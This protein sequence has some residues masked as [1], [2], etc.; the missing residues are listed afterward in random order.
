[1][2]VIFWGIFR[3]ETFLYM[4]KPL[5]PAMSG[6]SKPNVA[7]IGAGPGGLASALLLAKSGVDVTVFERSS[8][9]GGRNKVFERDG[10]KFDLGPTFFHY[11]EVIEDIFKAIGMDAHEELRLHRLEMNYRLIFGQGGQLDCTSDLD[12][13]TER[14]RGLSGDSNANAFRRYVDD[15]RL[16]LA[17]S[18]ACLQEPWY[19]PT[20]LLSKRAMRVAG[21]LRPQRSVAGDLMKLF[22]DDRLMLAMSFQTKY[23]GM[24]P[25]NCPSLFTMLAFLEYEYGIFHP[26]GGLGSVSERMASIAKDLGV[27]FKMNEAVESVIM[28]GK[29][30]KGVR[31]ANGE[32]MADK[33]VMNADF[34]NGMTQLFPDKVRKK[35]SNKKIDKKKYSCSTFMLYL[36]IDKT[37]EELPHHQIYASS[38]YEKNLEDIEKNHK[39]T[40]DDP[41][42]YVQNAC[43]VDPSLAPEGCS[44]VYA[45]VPVSHIHEN[46]DWDKEKDAYRDRIIEQIETKLGFEGLRDHIVTEMVITPEDW[47]DHCYRGAVFNLAHGLDQMLWRRPK[48]QFD[49]INNLY[50][51]GGGTHPGS[52][53]PV[54]YES[55]RI[56]SKLLLDSLG[57]IPDWNGVD[58]WFE[59]RKRSKQGRAA[60][61]K[62]SKEP[63]SGTPTSA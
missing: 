10:F 8:A 52:G 19:G 56:S 60:L 13:M 9:V 11:P 37:Y 5:P 36:G 33:V 54:I 62:S 1:L 35:W 31:T 30:I 2:N 39:L 42:I 40:W 26:I 24:S 28:D 38:N 61:N 23:L 58:T 20:D 22:D 48:N 18:K 25:F 21:V 47:G 34:A 7:I 15:N 57:I 41:S 51:V 29:T 43:V 49:E 59:S 4:L 14:I 6:R 55:A 12:E 45:L 17:K 63:S 32:F 50:L 3:I 53:L 44:T 16:K 46:I 27:T